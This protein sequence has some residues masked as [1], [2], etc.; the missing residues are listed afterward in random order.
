MKK[1]A[2]CEHRL[3]LSKKKLEL[4]VKKSMRSR[5]EYP[6]MVL[7]R[8]LSSHAKHPQRASGCLTSRD[9]SGVRGAAHARGWHCPHSSGYCSATRRQASCSPKDPITNRTRSPQ[10]L[11]VTNVILQFHRWDIV[12]VEEQLWREISK[13]KITYVNPFAVVFQTSLE[14]NSL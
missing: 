7:L 9:G 4:T 10:L 2:P 5:H 12:R 11:H 6:R 14:Q 8:T 1:R 13:K 3:G